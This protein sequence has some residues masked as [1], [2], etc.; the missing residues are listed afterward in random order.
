[1]VYIAHFFSFPI[2]L[3]RS[4]SLPDFHFFMMRI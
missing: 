2:L 3:F 4:V 1:M